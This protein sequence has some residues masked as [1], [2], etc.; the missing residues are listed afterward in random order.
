VSLSERRPFFAISRATTGVVGLLNSILSLVTGLLGGLTGGLG[1]VV[2]A[3]VIP[4]GSSQA[5]IAVMANA[6]TVRSPR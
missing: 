4:A 1:G 2:P 3:A 6:A 5:A